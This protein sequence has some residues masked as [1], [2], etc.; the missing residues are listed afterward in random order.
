M[1]LKWSLVL[2]VAIGILAM[3]QAYVLPFIILPLGGG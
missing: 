3:I 2:T 1:T